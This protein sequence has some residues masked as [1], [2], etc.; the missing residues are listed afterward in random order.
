M[1]VGRLLAAANLSTLDFQPLRPNGF[2]VV[3]RTLHTSRYIIGGE[4]APPGAGAIISSL[5]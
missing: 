5:P 1:S 3:E 2:H 4:T